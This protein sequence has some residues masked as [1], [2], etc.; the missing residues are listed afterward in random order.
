MIPVLMIWIYLTGSEA[1][2]GIFEDEQYVEVRYRNQTR[3]ITNPRHNIQRDVEKSLLNDDSTFI[4]SIALEF[5][6]PLI[7]KGMRTRI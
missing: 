6:S 2:N 7:T 4:F 3:I 5:K 1:E